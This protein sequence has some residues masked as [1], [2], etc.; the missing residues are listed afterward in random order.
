[1]NCLY[2]NGALP[3]TITEFAVRVGKWIIM[4]KNDFLRR[5]F[6]IA[7]AFSFAA[8]GE[9]VVNMSETTPTVVA[10]S[11][12][13]AE[14]AGKAPK[15]IF[16]F[17]GD[18]MSFPQIQASGFYRGVKQHGAINPE[19]G[20]I[21]QAS[22]MF[23]TTFPVV[24]A[25]NSYNSSSY[26]PD[27]AATATSLSSGIRTLSGVLNMDETKQHKSVSIAEQ[28]KQQLDYK[29][30]IVT[31]VNIDH[32][33]PAAYYAHVPSR[34]DYYDIGM[35]LLK[36]NYDYF[37]GGDFLSNNSKQVTK[38]GKEKIADL[39]AKEGYY[40]ANTNEKFRSLKP[41][42]GK[43]IVIC[44]Q[45]ELETGT[46]AMKYRLDQK[47]GDITLADL[48]RKGIE[49]LTANNDKG[50]FMMVEGGKIDWG[51]HAN[52][53]FTVINETMAFEEAVKVASEYYDKY[54]EETLIIVTGDH[55]TG[56]L[57]IGFAGTNYDTYF[58]KL[59]NQKT[60]YVEF[61]KIVNTYKDKNVS[62]EDALKDVKANFGLMTE[63]DPDAA[64]KKDMVLTEYE[65]GKLKAAFEM[66]K[67]GRTAKEQGDRVLYGGYNPF[68]VTLTHV[69][70]N[71]A[72]VNFASYAHTGLPVALYAKGV[73]SDAFAG[74]YDNVD[75]CKKLR[76]LTKVK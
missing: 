58:E 75:V 48:T 3:L 30:G 56:G 36:S 33:T 2:V 9:C 21:P 35:D 60:S 41:E 55:E 4:I 53:A 42:N 59:G 37:A 54:P 74:A 19:A 44:P 46:M 26:C 63:S 43:T 40:I 66:V 73:G 62:F 22:P 50:F 10:A 16:M 11:D 8:T 23:F 24:G 45:D 68:V 12:D 76:A 51:C 18:G 13:A 7:L 64:A 32:A 67:D 34:S 20:R 28:V 6:V 1:M 69:L 72:G 39:A 14:Y 70:N 15:Y 49:I 17:I 65:L 38:E 71:K 29:V 57:T 61:E 47:D 27:S 52:D 31:S 5:F 25:V